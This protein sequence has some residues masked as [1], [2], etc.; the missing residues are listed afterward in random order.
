MLPLHYDLY[1]VG[2]SWA[3]RQVFNTTMIEAAIRANNLPAAIGLV[4][5]LMSRKPHSQ[6]LNQLLLRLRDK[7]FTENTR[8]PTKKIK[9]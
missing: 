4:S 6:R 2:G 7:Y 9:L 8:S 3:Q 5:E 1:H